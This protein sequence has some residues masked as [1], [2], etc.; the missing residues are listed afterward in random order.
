MTGEI[1]MFKYSDRR[2]NKVLWHILVTEEG[3]WVAR[4][5]ISQVQIRESL[6]IPRMVKTD[7]CNLKIIME[8]SILCTL[9]VLKPV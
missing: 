7:N 9:N 8:E 3:M 4:S 2:R 5:Y 1:T 6:S